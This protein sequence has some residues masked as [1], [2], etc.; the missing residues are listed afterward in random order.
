M[1]EFFIKGK[2]YIYGLGYNV[3]LVSNCISKNGSIIASSNMNSC[4]VGHT[5]LMENCTNYSSIRGN[6]CVGAFIG[7]WLSYS[8]EIK[9]CDNYG[10]ISG[11]RYVAGI[12]GSPS[13]KFRIENCDNYG[14]IMCDENGAAGIAA[15]VY[16]EYKEII[17]CKNYGNVTAKDSAAGGITSYIVAKAS[18]I[19]CYSEGVVKGASGEFAGLVGRI[20]TAN[21][22]GFIIKDC[23]IKFDVKKAYSNI[24]IAYIEKGVNIDISNIEI[25][26]INQSRTVHMIGTCSSNIKCNISNIKIISKTSTEK[27]YVTLAYKIKKNADFTFSGIMFDTKCKHL[28][29]EVKE[30]G[31]LIDVKSCLAISSA[32][33][34]LYY[35]TD[36]SDFYYNRKTGNVDLISFGISNGF[37]TEIDE[38]WLLEKGYKLT[39]V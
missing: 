30:T 15:A 23:K 20:T 37:Q 5:K 19:G 6:A 22:N 36:F 25:E 39:A 11:Y 34:K 32:N 12:V 1:D 33:G 9:N 38:K 8:S 26:L 4:F 31:A 16:T 21:G 13:G 29:T 2:G 7:E 10:D 17:N 18:I 14:E 28:I 35:G 27:H 3:S 24:L